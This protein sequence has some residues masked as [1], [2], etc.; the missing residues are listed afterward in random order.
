M[1]KRDINQS[2]FDKGTNLK[3]DIFR[4]CFREWFPVLA[5][6]IFTQKLYIFDL[7]A[8]SGTDEE[9]EYG[10]PLILLDEARGNNQKFCHFVNNQEK[11]ISFIFNEKITKK[12]EILEK[13]VGLYFDK[14]ESDCT[15]GK[16]V[17]RE[18]YEIK[19]NDFIKNIGKN[20]LQSGVGYI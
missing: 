10:S 8:G 19:N 5:N 9:G 12:A 13:N 16:C 15:L 18:K 20:D 4:E 14:C 2:K 17:Y 3:L 6:D 11:D 7:F 1:A